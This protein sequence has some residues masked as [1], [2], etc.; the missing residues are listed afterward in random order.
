MKFYKSLAFLITFFFFTDNSFSQCFEIESILVDAC[1]NGTN[2]GY[3]EMFRM[4]IGTTPLNTNTLNINWPAQTWLGLVQNA[5]TTSKV[6]QLNNAIL[7]AGGCGQI[8][9]PIGGVL[10]A[11]STVIVV[12]SPNLDTTLNSFG[13]LT[14]NIYMLFQDT[15]ANPNAGHFGN[16]NAT[17][18]TR[19]L[20]VTFGGGCS[21]SVT[22]QRANLINILGTVGGAISDLNGSTVNFSPTGTPTYVNNGCTAPIPPFTVEAGTTPITA[23]PGQTINLSGTAQGQTSIVWSAL[24]GSFSNSGNLVTNYTIPTTAISGSTITLTLTVTNVCNTS[25]S[26]NIVINISG[27]TLSLSSAIGTTNQSICSGTAIAPIQYTFGGGATSATVFGLPTGVTA[28]TSGNVVAISGTPSAD[29]SYTINTVGG[30]GSVSL[31]GTISLSNNATLTLDAAN[32][33]QAICSGTAIA[34]IQ[35]TFGGGATSATVSGL[36]TGVTAS[37]SGNVVTI[38]GT[39]ATDFSYTINTVGGCGTTTQNGTVAFSSNATL[40]LNSSAA[41]TNQFVCINQSI[42][43]ISYSFGGGATGVTITGLPTSVNATTIGNTVT[44][45]GTPTSDFTYS[46]TTV[47]GCGSV[48]LNGSVTVTST[49]VTLSLNSANNTQNI[50]SGTAIAPIQYTFGGSATS[51]NVTD[52]PTGV[53][54]SI[55]G[56]SVTISGTPTTAFNY[57]VFTVGG[58][59]G[60][61]TG[62]SVTFLTNTATLAIDS[63]NNTQNICSGSTII[64]I[65]YTFGGGATSATVSGL[66]TGVT[67]SISGNV[68]TISG[69]PTANFSYTINTVG[70]CGSVSLNGT[71]SLS[72]NATL[73]LDAANNN[74]AIC[75]GTAIAPIQYTFGGGATSATVSGIP[76]GVTASISGNVVTISGTPTTA[77]SYTINTVG[78]C[79]S[80]SLNGTISLSNNA[81]LTLDGANNNQAICSGTAIAPIQYTFGG[82]ATS[83]TVS[84]I[85]TGVTA[86][87]SGNV[88]TISGTP[89]TN[90]SYTINTVGGCGSVSLNGTVSLSNNA[91]LPTFDPIGP[92]CEGIITNSPLP[93]ISTNGISGTWSPNFNNTIT[94]TYVF[95]PDF[96]QCATSTSLTIQI[97]PKPTITYSVTDTICDGSTLDFVLNSSLPNTSYIWSATVSNISGSYSITTNGDETNINQ[98]ATLTDSENIGTITMVIIP[99]ANGCYG[100]ASNPIVITVNPIPLVESVSVADSSVCS[101]TNTTNNVHVDIVGNISGITYTWTAITSGVNVVG[102]PTS[103]TIIAT[104]TTAMIDL[105]VVTSNPLVAGTI[106]FEVTPIR[107]GCPGNLLTSG[108]VTVNPNPGLPIS[109]PVKTIC[110]GNSTDLMIDVSPLI[111]GTQLT[112]EV[113]TVVNVTGATPGTG[114]APSPINDVLTATTNTQGYVIYRVRSTLGDC[115]GGYTDYRVNVNPSPLPILTDGNICIT[116]TGEVYQTYILNTGLNDAD[117]DFEW[118]D[119]NGTVI[120]GATNSTLV[121]DAAGTY[122]VIATNWLTGC[123]SDPLL[124][125]ATATVTATTPGTSMT[126][127]QSEYFSENATIIVTVPDGSGTLMYS[128]DEGALQSSNT[129]TGVSAGEHIVTVIDT[130]GCTYMTQEVMVIDY[131]TYFTPNGD[132][133]ND[134]WNIVG[135]N[136]ADAKLYIYDRYGKLLKQLSATQD[137]NGWDGT[138]NQEQL[139]STDYWFTL[140]YTENGVAKQ[141]KAHFSLKQ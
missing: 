123:S 64:P 49:I 18:A 41:S 39:P 70:G 15:P 43:P 99:M 5:T 95:T 88:V 111:T 40:T 76:T 91:N 140:D 105:Q 6:N 46:I 38:S 71:V 85:P 2:E 89:A 118:F 9:E 87:I 116:A 137:S 121:V 133:I 128:L 21:D 126:I 90:F 59:G 56:N 112:W 53:T 55:I 103:G 32:N 51:V 130:E 35:Y 50:C 61:A 66:P 139:P 120:A 75:S 106:Y 135:L 109:S 63:A 73:T 136:Q 77:F 1:D 25:L 65:Q 52:L 54:A 14:S 108:I 80:V 24:N 7:A 16:Y 42:N 11:N 110:S 127:V 28:S 117:Y 47:G 57:S 96:N 132:G 17:P 60:I 36:P 122:S 12:S 45:N 102:G 98:I 4:K 119:S 84:G 125:S 23:C 44:I 34:P 67:A 62:G 81:T 26:D 10:P 82:G 8:L 131:P 20:S 97:T 48:T 33:N 94:Q 86:S 107:N 138:H 93:T 78:G 104:S 69:T 72:N 31:N 13:A 129:F 29:F 141:F 74:Q 79:G 58:C 92:I 3:N 22:Y 124:S 115:Q 83:A 113:L 134:T 30:C 114:V 101:A 37:I 27:S 100:V 19:T 68:V